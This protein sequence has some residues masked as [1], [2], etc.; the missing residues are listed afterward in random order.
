MWEISFTEHFHRDLRN[1]P[2]YCVKKADKI[3]VPLQ[4]DF[5]FRRK[6]ATQLK[7]FKGVC[8]IRFGDYRMLYFLNKEKQQI[9]LISFKH[10]K[11]VYQ[12][13]AY[14]NLNNL[15]YIHPIKKDTPSQNILNLLLTDKQKILRTET[16]ERVDTTVYEIEE[17][18]NDLFIQPEELSLMNVPS[19]YHKDILLL[20]NEKELE[21]SDLPDSIK[22]ILIEYQTSPEPTQIG[23]LYTLQL[24]DNLN[25]IAKHPLKKF[26]ITLDKQQKRII[27]IDFSKGP[28]IVRG[29][30]GTGKTIIGLYRL[31]RMLRERAT[32]SI[33]DINRKKY[34]G[35]ITYT[36]SLV[37]T[38]KELFESIRPLNIDDVEVTFNTLDQIAKK[39]VF[40]YYYS[41]D[42][43]PPEVFEDDQALEGALIFFVLKKMKKSGEDNKVIAAETIEKLYS[44]SFLRKEITEVIEGQNITTKE[45]YILADRKGRKTG[46]NEARRQIFWTAY[47]VFKAHCK[48]RN[49]C[50]WSG[51]RQEALN[52]L[53][54]GS[55]YFNPF[56]ALFVDEIQDLSIVSLRLC[57]ELIRDKRFLLFAADTGQ[58]I[59]NQAP[60]WKDVHP[61]L[62]FHRGN[63][64][65]LPN[66]YRMTKQML[67]ALKVLRVELN[68]DDNEPVGNGKAIYSGPKPIWLNVPLEDHI[69]ATKIE[70]ER[71]V[72][73]KEINAGQIAIILRSTSK[74]GAVYKKAIEDLNIKCDFYIKGNPVDI[75]GNSIHLITCHS[76]KGLEFPFVILPEVSEYNYPF[77]YVLNN[78]KNDDERKEIED[79]EKR[80]LY[81]AASRACRQL[82]MIVDNDAPSPFV[83]LLNP[84]QWEFQSL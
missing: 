26:L 5:S 55:V 25:T 15:Q 82:C 9:I 1:I 64:F 74:R 70:I 49:R 75:H 30:P 2:E 8:K 51:R 43:K 80:L 79:N 48:S 6:M 4:K 24:D 46:L 81:V 28:I 71:L 27:G 16:E 50:T 73:E 53:L 83:K 63:S 21:T 45:E 35:F 23:K 84:E 11:N 38:N 19:Q 44:T 60:R 69:D 13:L 52:H 54:Q 57:V 3:L 42:S 12:E 36:N 76:A 33:F 68:T 56:D 10:R 65:I 22:S 72:N 20:K 37:E 78:T 29:G 62:K 66:N 40:N 32:E 14:P 59:Y 67:E 39:I 58:S 41:I 18:I 61:E 31:C 17:K 47:Q 7:A 77:Q 34:F